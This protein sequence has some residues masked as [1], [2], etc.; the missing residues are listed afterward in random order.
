MGCLIVKDGDSHAELISR[1]FESSSKEHRL[2]SN[3]Y[4]KL[5]RS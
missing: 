4:H 2:Y 5:F 3:E 1:S